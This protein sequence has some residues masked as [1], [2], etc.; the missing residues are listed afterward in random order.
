MGKLHRKPIDYIGSARALIRKKEPRMR[1]QD[2]LF[3]LK[4]FCHYAAEMLCH[5]LVVNIPGSMKFT[6]YY[7]NSS[8]PEEILKEARF[9]RS[10]AIHGV[11]FSMKCTGK[12]PDEYKAI[13]KPSTHLRGKM[14]EFLTEP[15]LTYKLII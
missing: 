8:D 11:Y 7:V 4:R 15:D 1:N 2:V 9:A 13:F 10:A 14:E 3:I 6:P 12:F 5:G